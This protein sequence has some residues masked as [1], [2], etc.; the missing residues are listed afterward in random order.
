MDFDLFLGDLPIGDAKISSM[1][2]FPGYN[3]AHFSSSL[4]DRDIF[5]N[6]KTLLGELISSLSLE[7]VGSTRGKLLHLNGRNTTFD[8]NGI[9]WL[10]PI[11]QL[12]DKDLPV[13]INEQI[14]SAFN[15]SILLTMT[16]D[17]KTKL[18]R[19]SIQCKLELPFESEDFL[20]TIR[21]VGYF[22]DISLP[23][24]DAGFL[25]IESTMN[26]HDETVL[27]RVHTFNSSLVGSNSSIIEENVLRTIFM[28]DF[29][30]A[31]TV[32]LNVSGNMAADLETPYGEGR[33]SGIKVEN[34]IWQMKGLHG[35]DGGGKS[36]VIISNETVIG[37]VWT[38]ALQIENPSD[39]F[40]DVSFTRL[41]S[42]M[43]NAN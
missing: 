14:F 37:N 13:A 15:T 32:S 27:S 38:I 18:K 39:M 30:K 28:P 36:K 23:Q 1:K 41:I 2:I 12:F 7:E 34:H 6:N 43:H 3:H 31:E 19:G 5:R 29:I 20:I 8:G 24:N 40:V 33:I 21:G 22:L 26:S 16:P 42:H 11:I 25:R 9:G 35:L 4:F 10:Q 17:G